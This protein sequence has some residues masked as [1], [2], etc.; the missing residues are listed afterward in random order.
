MEMCLTV[1]HIS[2]LGS[3]GADC[4][5]DFLCEGDHKP[6]EQTQGAQLKMSIAQSST[7]ILLRHLFLAKGIV[8]PFFL[9]FG[10]VISGWLHLLSPADCSCR[11]RSRGLGYRD[12]RRTCSTDPCDTACDSDSS[13]TLGM[14][15]LRSCSSY[16]RACPA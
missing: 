5:E 4:R 3:D 2:I 1:R 13:C 8:P 15:R 12:T 10:K 14:G 11:W 6:A 7:A 16:R 9:F